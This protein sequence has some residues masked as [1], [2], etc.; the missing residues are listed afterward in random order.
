VARLLYRI[1]AFVLLP[2]RVWRR[3]GRDLQHTIDAVLEDA[4]RGGSR[5]VFL[6]YMS[7][8]RE[9]LRGAFQLRFGVLRARETPQPQ[10]DLRTSNTRSNIMEGWI[11]EMRLAVRSLVK[12]PGFA[13]LAIITLALGIGANTAIFSVIHGAILAQLPFADPDRLVWL[14][15]GHE[16]LSPVGVNQTVPNLLD[17]RDGSR[18]MQSMAIYTTGNANLATEESPDRV[19]L[20]MVSSEWLSVLGTPPQFGRDLAPEDDVAGAPRVALLTDEIWRTRFGADP[21][22]VGQN[23]SIDSEPVQVAG[24][25]PPEFR[26]PGNPQVI[27]P[28][29]HDGGDFSRGWRN[30]NGVGRLAEGAE[31]ENLSAELQSIFTRL[32]EE[33][34]GPNEGWSTGAMPLRTMMAGRN[35]QS[36]YLL[37]GGVGLVLLI[38]CVNVANLLIVRAENRHRELAIRYSMGARRAELLSHFLSEGLVLSLAGG[39]LGVAGAYWGVDLLMAL[40]GS[41]LPRADEIG[42]NGTVLGFAVLVS[43]L[44]GLLVGLVPLI[45]SRPDDLQDSLKEGARGA[46]AQGSRL[47]RVLVIAEVALAVLIVAAAGLLTNSLWQMQQ[48]EL[49]VS[50]VDRVLTFNISLP[51]AKYSDA[52]SINEFYDRIT[53]EIEPVPGVEAV[54]LVNRLPLLGGS[55]LTNFP[56]YGDPE[57]VS[58]FVS[59]RAVSPGYFDAIGVPLLAGRWLSASEFADSTTSSILINETLARELFQGGDALGQLV[60]PDWTDGGY[61][62]VGVVGDIMG[63]NPTRP[64]PPAF[65]FPMVLDPGLFRSVVVK[66]RGDP[67]TL[68]PTL[69][70]VVRRMDSEVPIFQ[71]RTLEE[72]ARQRLGMGRFAQSLFGVFAALALLLGAVGIYGVMSFAVSRR[73]REFGVRLA[74]GA[75]RGSVLRLVLGQGARLTIP[76]VFVGL[77]A[78]MGAARL[79]ESILFEVSPLDP[80]TYV[81]VAV[82]LG[83]V[84]L[85]ASYLP[86]YRATRLDPITSLREE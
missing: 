16:D 39:A 24:V 11:R 51:Q 52:A 69:R 78:A 62:V 35:T 47:G 72:I 65:Y 80:L 7:E 15:D 58:H 79:M 36:L 67:L 45:R 73:A 49:G 61:L 82:V 30:F 22:I 54:G 60:G 17:L 41:T 38:A 10:F 50:D 4:R 3:T 77:A 29:Q 32:V 1:L 12:R 43:V 75:S 25:A 34:P 84:S 40:Y 21:N 28:L 26:F 33:Y 70:Q 83:V 57:R 71:T 31:V 44:V 14:S 81:A 8:L 86:A 23:L 55:N 66:G 46:S 68:L 63:G 85:G 2:R 48:V 64:A 76:G 5:K 27:V 37:A 18:L 9:L 19:R 42:L 56:V 13:A 74:L 20:L 59:Y 53:V 6:A